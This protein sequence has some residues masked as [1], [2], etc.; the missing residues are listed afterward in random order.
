MGQRKNSHSEAGVPQGFKSSGQCHYSV[1]F[2]FIFMNTGRKSAATIFSNEISVLNCCFTSSYFLKGKND[3][4]VL[5]W[6]IVSL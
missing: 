5:K 4:V 6:E 2:T 1:L 3:A